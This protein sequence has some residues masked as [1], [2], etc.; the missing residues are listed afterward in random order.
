MITLDTQVMVFDV[1]EPRR[2]SR[3]AKQALADAS[4]SRSLACSDICL[5]E[6]AMLAAKGRIDTQGDTAAF[7][8]DLLLARHIRVLPITP[9]IAALAQSDMFVQRDSADRIIAATAIEHGVPLI[10]ADA[11]LRRVQALEVIW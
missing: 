6:L 4:A 1:L 3:R 10:T 9:T 11:E 8:D 2:L 7:I 5:W